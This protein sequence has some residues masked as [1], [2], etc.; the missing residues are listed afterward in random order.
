MRGGVVHFA[1]QVSRNTWLA[2]VPTVL[3]QK[4]PLGS[5]SCHPRTAPA[6]SAS[7]EK[8]AYLKQVIWN[9]KQIGQIHIPLGGGKGLRVSA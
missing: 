8:T 4:V 9:L 3:R 6:L 1:Q 5:H 7:Q 2:Q